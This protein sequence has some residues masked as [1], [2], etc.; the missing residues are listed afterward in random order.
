MESFKVDPVIKVSIPSQK[1]AC[2]FHKECLTSK[3]SEFSS[4]SDC[5]FFNA[6]LSAALKKNNSLRTPCPVK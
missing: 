3:T 5:G 1:V 6:G 2:R 4:R